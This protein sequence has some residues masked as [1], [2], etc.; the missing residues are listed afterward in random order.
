MARF[1]RSFRK[2]FRPK[3]NA[4]RVMRGGSDNLAVGVTTTAYT[5][6]ARE[7]GVVKSIRLDAGVT[8]SDLNTEPIVPYALVVVREGYDANTLTY[9]ALNADMYNPTMDVLI[10]GILTSSQQEDHKFNMIGRKM[11]TGDRLFLWLFCRS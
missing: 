1:R 5:F 4:E 3:R 6:T 7:A 2:S 10:S 11:K 9:P 8:V